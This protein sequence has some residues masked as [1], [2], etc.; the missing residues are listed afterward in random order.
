MTE[1]I[2]FEEYNEAET[3]MRNDLV[4]VMVKYASKLGKETA[5]AL[6]ANCLSTLFLRM[7][8]ETIENNLSTEPFEEIIATAIELLKRGK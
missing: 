5:G 1:K 4:D 8:S 6:F 2:S 3:K 7:L